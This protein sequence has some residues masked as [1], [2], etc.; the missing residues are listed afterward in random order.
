MNWQAE[1]KNAYNLLKDKLYLADGSGYQVK[2]SSDPDYENRDL[3]NLKCE[4]DK[5]IRN[6][7]L[8]DYKYWTKRIYRQLGIMEVI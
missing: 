6:F 4:I 1:F 7:K 8:E 2:T 3:I 5:N